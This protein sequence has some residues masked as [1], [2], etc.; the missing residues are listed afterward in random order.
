MS[1]YF[2]KQIDIEPILKDANKVL[3][4][5]LKK[6][7]YRFTVS[8]IAVQI[9]KCKEDIEKHKRELNDAYNFYIKT[10]SDNDTE[11]ETVLENDDIDDDETITI[12]ES[13]TTLYAEEEEEED[14]EDETASL[15]DSIISEDIS[16]SSNK[17]NEDCLEENEEHLEEEQHL[18]EVE[19]LEE[20]QHLE[21][22]MALKIEDISD[23]HSVESIN[24]FLQT[25]SLHTDTLQNQSVAL[26]TSIPL[27]IESDEEKVE[28]EEGEEEEQE[29]KEDE[30]EEKEEEEEEAEEEEEQQEE[31]E[32]EEEEEEQ[33]KDE[34]EEVE[35]E[36]EEDEDEE[37]FEIEIDDKT[38]YT[39]DENNGT[40]YEVDE[41]GEPGDKI[42][43]LKNGE[44]IFT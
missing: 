10:D 22:N 33:E 7:L 28:E 17:E 24:T 38:Y 21:E 26:T 20:E 16:L 14:E 36:E 39:N 3:K 11:S 4:R 42:G 34:T 29:E 15:N 37:V 1:E 5:G 40:L 2:G 9:K 31:K 44:P 41:N 32:D 43:Y 12:I 25:V 35:E 23:N 19:H 6:A 8:R 18:E 30:T 27:Y 13:E